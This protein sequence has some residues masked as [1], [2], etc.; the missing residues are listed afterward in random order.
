MYVARLPE[1]CKMVE[2]W[3]ASIQHITASANGSAASAGE[4]NT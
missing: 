2:E 4:A 1:P 3:Q